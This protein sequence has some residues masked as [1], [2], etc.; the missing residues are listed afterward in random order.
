METIP[1]FDGY[2]IFNVSSWFETYFLALGDKNEN[3]LA[4]PCANQA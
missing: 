3:F 1:I 2:S 4:K